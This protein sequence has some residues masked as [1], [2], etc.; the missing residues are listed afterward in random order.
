MINQQ[1]QDRPPFVPRM[2]RRFA[3][4]I[5]LAWLGILFALSTQVPPLQQVAKDHSVSLDPLDAPS[6][7]A[8]Q[9]IGTKF[10][11]PE[12]SSVAMVV[13]EGEQ[14]LAEDTRDY[15]KRLILSLI[16]I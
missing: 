11:Q 3:P 14:P 7:K 8:I 1:V 12:S 9:R 13:L 2:I 15:Y 10:T 16:H 5:I 4:L 6:Y